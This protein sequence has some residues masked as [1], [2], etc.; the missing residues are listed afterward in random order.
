M[1]AENAGTGRSQNYIAKRLRGDL[2]FTL[3]E[4]DR[5]CAHLGL[6]LAGIIAKV[7]RDLA[8]RDQLEGEK[9]VQER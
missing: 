3:D 6:D 9:N 2:P 1:L 4:L 5:I 8:K 7:H